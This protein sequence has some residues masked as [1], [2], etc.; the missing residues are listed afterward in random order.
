MN[1]LIKTKNTWKLKVASASVNSDGLSIF[2]TKCLS[3]LSKG[4]LLYRSTAD[5]TTIQ[6]HT[7]TDTNASPTVT[8]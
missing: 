3:G 4:N 7:V 6:V 1:L 8:Q 2:Q 5:K